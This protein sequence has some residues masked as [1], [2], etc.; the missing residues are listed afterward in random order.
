MNI[1]RRLLFFL[2][3]EIRHVAVLVLP[4]VYGSAASEPKNVRRTEPRLGIGL[5]LILLRHSSH[6]WILIERRHL[7]LLIRLKSPK[8][9]LLLELRL[10]LLLVCAELLTHRL[11]EVCLELVWLLLLRLLLLLLL[12]LLVIA[13]GSCHH[14][15]VEHRDGIVVRAHES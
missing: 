13:G 4:L 15:L 7:L 1:I 8:L 6:H 10:L 11:L 2:F 12:R 3:Q 14:N 9:W 5:E